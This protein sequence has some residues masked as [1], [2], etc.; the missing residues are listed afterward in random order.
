LESG[1]GRGRLAV[2][3]GKPRHQWFG[4]VYE[5]RAFVAAAF[6]PSE[7]NAAVAS[8]TNVTS[9]RTRRPLRRRISGYIADSA[10]CR[11]WR[12]SNHSKRCYA[13]RRGIACSTN[14]K[15]RVLRVPATKQSAV[16]STTWRRYFLRSAQSDRALCS[17]KGPCFCIGLIT[18]RTLNAFLHFFKLEAPGIA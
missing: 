16:K 3:S 7:P 10:G 18:L 6:I 9:F 11:T 17:G 4:G 2:H 13:A 8:V 5:L 12:D 14:R 15:N 1:S